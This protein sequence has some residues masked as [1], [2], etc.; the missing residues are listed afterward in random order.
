[1]VL[2]LFLSPAI[3]AASIDGYRRWSHDGFEERKLPVW[4]EKAKTREGG[5]R[6][7][8]EKVWQTKERN[9]PTRSESRGR[10]S[11]DATQTKKCGLHQPLSDRITH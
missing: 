3:L 5:P 2:L 6:N 7:F 8:M 4:L 1:L 10:S 9:M 11:P